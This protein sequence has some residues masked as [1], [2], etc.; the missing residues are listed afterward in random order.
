MCY[1]LLDFLSFTQNFYICAIDHDLLHFSIAWCSVRIV[2]FRIQTYAFSLLFD[3]QNRNICKW[4][5]QW[6]KSWTAHTM[7][8][9]SIS[10]ITYSSSGWYGISFEEKSAD[11]LF[12][13][14]NCFCPHLTAPF[15]FPRTFSG[16]YCFSS[17]MNLNH[18]KSIHF[19]Q[20]SDLFV[21]SSAI[22]HIL[23]PF[24][25]FLFSYLI[26]CISCFHFYE[27]GWFNRASKL[28][29]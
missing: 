14:F 20:T 16:F 11:N 6:K 28:R 8:R 1:F 10:L 12:F 25:M 22:R 9:M 24:S 4:S 27:L 19:D 21:F 2:D 3:N 17:T 5:A 15:Y 29:Q 23:F 26:V 7:H 18:P 13:F